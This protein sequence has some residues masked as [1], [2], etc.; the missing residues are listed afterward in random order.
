MVQD[1][2]DFLEKIKEDQALKERM[3]K[4]VKES[5]Q[6]NMFANCNAVAAEMGYTITQEDLKTY[7]DEYQADLTDEDLD[8]VAGG[9]EL[10][11]S[12]S[13][14]LSAATIATSVVYAVEDKK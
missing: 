3:G 9:T 12:C 11:I 14:L 7:A 13:I 2:K 4:I 8:K 10:L 1:L 6:E 5:T